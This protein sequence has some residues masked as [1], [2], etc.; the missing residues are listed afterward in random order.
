MPEEGPPPRPRGEGEEDEKC[1]HLKTM[2]KDAAIW[3]F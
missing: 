1:S 3:R 2:T